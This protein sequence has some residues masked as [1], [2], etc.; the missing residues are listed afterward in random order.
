MSSWFLGALQTFVIWQ[1]IQ[2]I[3]KKIETLHE[4]YFYL[5]PLQCKMTVDEL[6]R[7]FFECYS[8]SCGSRNTGKTHRRRPVDTVFVF[9]AQQHVSGGSEQI[10]PDRIF[11]LKYVSAHFS[12]CLLS[13]AASV[14]SKI[15][16]SPL[17]HPAVEFT[18]WHSSQERPPSPRIGSYSV[19]CW[20]LLK[21]HSSSQ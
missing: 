15:P 20:G 8:E 3:A 14:G 11:P 9:S 2:E 4:I 5:K 19:F 17:R 18:C 13:H 6:R 21:K 12:H 1:Y 10:A 16:S 7:W